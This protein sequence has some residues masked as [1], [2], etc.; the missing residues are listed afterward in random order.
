[1]RLNFRRSKVTFFKRSKELSGDQK[2]DQEIKSHFF[3]EIK[4]FNNI[5]KSFDHEI[6]TF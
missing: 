6:N 5:F 1:M 4:S 2:N 3:Q